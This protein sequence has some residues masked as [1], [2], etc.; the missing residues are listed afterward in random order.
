MEE[1]IH[2]IVVEDRRMHVREITETGDTSTEQVQNILHENLNTKK[3]AAR[4]LTT[5]TP[6]KKT[7]QFKSKNNDW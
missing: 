7:F 6:L 1:K 2:G 4:L 3:L 5:K